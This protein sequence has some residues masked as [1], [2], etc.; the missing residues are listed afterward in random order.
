MLS[1]SV[2]AED[3]RVDGPGEIREEE[4][5]AVVVRVQDDLLAKEKGSNLLSGLETRQVF[6]VFYTRNSRCPAS[7]FQFWSHCVLHV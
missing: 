6:D 1:V 2:F 5:Y 7:D 4:C 3:L